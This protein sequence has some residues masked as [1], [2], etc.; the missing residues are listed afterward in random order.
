[1]TR[2]SGDDKLAAIQ[3]YL[4]GEE[5]Y[6]TIAKSIGTTD[7][8]VVRNWVMQYEEHSIEVLLKNHIQVILHC[9]N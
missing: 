8:S 6:I 3:R 2:F 7:D 9:L 1:M 5:S 4:A